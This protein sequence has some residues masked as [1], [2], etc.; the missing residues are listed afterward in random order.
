[1]NDPQISGPERAQLWG[2]LEV[3]PVNSSFQ[4]AKPG[5]PV[6]ALEGMGKKLSLNH[7]AWLGEGKI[8]GRKKRK[9][10]IQKFIAKKM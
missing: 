4:L 8:M 1:M 9:R 10:M 3:A 2:K 6:N 7:G 5:I